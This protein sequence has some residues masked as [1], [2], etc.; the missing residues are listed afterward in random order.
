MIE[1]LIGKIVW[2]EHIMQNG[3][4]F[5]FPNLNQVFDF[6]LLLVSIIYLIKGIFRLYSLFNIPVK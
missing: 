2:E 5:V 4:S 3:Y 1:K 6:I